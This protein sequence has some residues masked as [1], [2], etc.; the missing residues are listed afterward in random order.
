MVTEDVGSTANCRRLLDATELI[1]YGP[2]DVDKI[3]AGNRPSILVF[4]ILLK[5]N[6]EAL[7]C[8][9]DAA[10]INDASLRSSVYDNEEL[11]RWL[12]LPNVR[13]HV[14]KQF[15][16]G[17]LDSILRKF[18]QVKWR[19]LVVPLTFGMDEQIQD[20]RPMPWCALKPVNHGGQAQVLHVA[21]NEEFVSDEIKARLGKEPF[22]IEN[23]G[24]CFEFAIKT[25]AVDS[26]TDAADAGW[27]AFQTEKAA[28]AGISGLSKR[29]GVLEFFGSYTHQDPQGNKTY[30][31]LLEFASTDLDQYL[32]D[33]FAPQTAVDIIRQWKSVCDVAH[34]IKTV[35]NLDNG[36]DA[37]RGLVITD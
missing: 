10:G 29:T 30:N 20:Y 1:K 9:F 23:Y 13:T 4:S 37:Y 17:S 28:L 16:D 7:I 36:S 27:V 6:Y 32:R 25:F 14:S 11:R 35:H 22:E 31:I 24:K 21:A 5:L 15:G 34:A 12:N 18:D 8:L 19:F 2:P 3:Y 26:F 33:E